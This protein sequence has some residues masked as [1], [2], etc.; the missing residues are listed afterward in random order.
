[1]VVDV[2]GYVEGVV[3][4]LVALLPRRA[5]KNDGT[6]WVIAPPVK[7]NLLNPRGLNQ[8]V[9]VKINVFYEYLVCLIFYG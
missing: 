4:P 8:S 3:E 9:S 7:T 2:V 1:M 5:L 6:M